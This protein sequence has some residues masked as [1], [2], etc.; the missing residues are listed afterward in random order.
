[1]RVC[2]TGAGG[3]IG[4]WLTAELGARGHEV[5]AQDLRRP[6]CTR[7]AWSTFRTFDLCD[8]GKWMHWLQVMRPDVVIHLA[9]LYGRVWGEVDMVKTAGMNAGLTA[10]LA[11]DCAVQGARMM[12]MSSSEVYGDIANQ[13]TVYAD[14][15]LRPMNMYGLSKKWSEEAAWLY[16]PD[17]LMVTR[18]NM[19]YGPAYWTPWPGEQPATSGKPGTV[20]Y[21]VLHSMLWEAEV[22]YDIVVHEGTSRCLTWVGDTVR[23]LVDI[24]E[25]ETSGTWNVNRND[26]HIDVA[27]LARMV[28]ELTDSKSKISVQPPP[29]RVTM[30]KSLDNGELLALGWEPTMD[31]AEGMKRTYEYFR[32]FDPSGVWRG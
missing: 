27:T 28:V 7:A 13:G 9:A 11:R 18:L 22:G 6:N 32:K 19:P 15:P 2:V 3:Y 20:G 21:N 29:E 24:M 10:M 1:M 4:G 26:D 17:G 14:S 30:R 25:S 5:H 23:G 8:Q 12:L 16:A 31:L